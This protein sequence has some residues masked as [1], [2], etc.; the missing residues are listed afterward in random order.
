MIELIVAMAIISVLIGIFLPNLRRAVAKSD[1]AACQSNLRNISTSIILYSN[2]NDRYYPGTLSVCVPRWLKAV[3]TCPAAHSDT[4]S[5]GYTI[6]GVNE[7]AN[8]ATTTAT[9]TIVC[10]GTN[11]DEIGLQADEPWYNVNRGIGP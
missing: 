3:P 2:D 6:V 7:S 5:G 11:H 8:T 4:Y 1:L 9:F 10:K